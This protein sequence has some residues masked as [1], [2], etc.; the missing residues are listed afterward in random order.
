LSIKANG[1]SNPIFGLL[2]PFV[3]SGKSYVLFHVYA[4]CFK[5]K[6]VLSQILFE[7]NRFIN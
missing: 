1:A 4:A 6:V 2:A 7:K 5:A 3:L